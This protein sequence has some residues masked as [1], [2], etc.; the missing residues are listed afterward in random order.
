MRR[1]LIIFPLVLFAL[2]APSAG[3][4]P[5]GRQG[6]HRQR[7]HVRG[8]KRTIHL[9]V[10]YVPGIRLLE[11]GIHAIDTSEAIEPLSSTPWDTTLS[12]GN[13]IVLGKRPAPH[14][15]G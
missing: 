6:N 1:L 2:C 13:A 11:P 5:G 12:N 4:G 9:R 8:G 14:G 3:T 15:L 10:N 7:E